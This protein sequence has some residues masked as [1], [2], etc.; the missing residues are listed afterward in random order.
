MSAKGESALP[1]ATSSG[2]SATR[3]D[4]KPSPGK[5][6]RDFSLDPAT[7]FLSYLINLYTVITFQSVSR[8]CL[9]VIIF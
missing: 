9:S 1:D 8:C 2:K 5:K 7:K 3:I 6:S 4:E